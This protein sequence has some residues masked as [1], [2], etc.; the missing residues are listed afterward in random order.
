MGICQVW[1]VCVLLTA[2]NEPGMRLEEPLAATRWEV[3]PEISW[4]RYEE[5]GVMKETGLLY[6]VAGAYTRTHG[7]NRLFRLEGEFAFGFVDYVGSLND[8]AN[9]PYRMEDSRDYLL[10]VRALWGRTW[11]E[12]GWDSRFYGGLGYRGL[13]DDSRH[14]PHGYDRQSNY[15][16]L[17]LGVKGYYPLAGAWELGLGGEFDLLLL[18]VQL[19]GMSDGGVLTNVQWP[20][21]GARFSLEFRHRTDSAD[22]AFAPF[23][24]YW[25]VDDSS[26]ESYTGEEW[27]EPR[28]SSV[29]LGASLIWRF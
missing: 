15:L 25:W 23:L 6:G 19:S 28:N 24:Q 7:Y 21:F 3:A 20:G 29:Q 22:V 14:D 18:G 10:N 9:T 12:G 1:A 4:F 17:P 2:A 27:Y 5:P 13:N 8:E 26:V 16:Y 11:Q